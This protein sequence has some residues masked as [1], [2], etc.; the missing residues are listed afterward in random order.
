MKKRN[1]R[2]PLARKQH[3]EF[4]DEFIQLVMKYLKID[5]GVRLG[6]VEHIPVSYVVL[7]EILNKWHDRVLD[8]SDFFFQP[9]QIQGI[10]REGETPLL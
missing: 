9:R 10:Y 6:N 2:N 8:Q 5:L 4:T 1:K 3:V 7:E